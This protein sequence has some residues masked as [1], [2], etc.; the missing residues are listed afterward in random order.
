MEIV[1]T[2]FRKSFNSSGQSMFSI[3]CKGAGIGA[4]FPCGALPSGCGF[5]TE[6][7]TL[8]LLAAVCAAAEPETF[9]SV[10]FLVMPTFLNA[11]QSKGT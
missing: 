5:W 8:P 4:R 2:A 6:H 9:F 3:L 10:R 11:G 1:T 7:T